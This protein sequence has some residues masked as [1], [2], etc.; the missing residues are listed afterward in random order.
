MK[1]GSSSRKLANPQDRRE[2]SSVPVARLHGV[3]SSGRILEPTT[4]TGQVRAV[5]GVPSSAMII[6]KHRSEVK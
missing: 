4:L 1:A 3:P 6:R 5:P 2:I